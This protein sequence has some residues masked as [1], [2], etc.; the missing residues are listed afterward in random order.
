M[1]VGNKVMDIVSN[2]NFLNKV[3]IN[4]KYFHRELNKLKEKFPKVIKEVR[5]RGFLIGLRLYKNQTD[6]I[7]FLMD[8]KLLT[9]K[10]AEN[11]V[12]ILPPLNVKKDEIN[13][14]LKIINKVCLIYK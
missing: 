12:R 11:T 2:K 1:S 5:G 4:S 3:K 6:F 9:I 8:N 13:Q 14:A 7:K 10:A